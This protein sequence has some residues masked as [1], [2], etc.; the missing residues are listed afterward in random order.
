MPELR[1][2]LLFKDHYQA[3]IIQAAEEKPKEDLL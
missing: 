3:V 1:L 2:T